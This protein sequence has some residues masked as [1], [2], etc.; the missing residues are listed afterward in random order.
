MKLD[1]VWFYD[2]LKFVDSRVSS[3]V[4]TSISLHTLPVLEVEADFCKLQAVNR[5][6]CTLEWYVGVEYKKIPMNFKWQT[7]SDSHCLLYQLHRK[8]KVVY[9]SVPARWGTSEVSD[10]PAGSLLQQRA[11]CKTGTLHQ[12][13]QGQ[14]RLLDAFKTTASLLIRVEK[15]CWEYCDWIDR[16]W[17]ANQ[18]TCGLCCLILQDRIVSMTLDKEYDVAV[19]A[20]K[21][22]TLVLK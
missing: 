17:W 4:I 19:Q 21:L 1:K 8:V 9:F 7:F 13:F 10:S 3:L 6:C 14:R 20:I 11:Q 18:T 12:P 2:D 22:L 16:L 15:Q 5:I